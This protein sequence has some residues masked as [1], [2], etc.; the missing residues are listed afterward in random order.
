LTFEHYMKHVIST[1]ASTRKEE[2]ET[3][4]GGKNGGITLWKK[5]R[6]FQKGKR[7]NRSLCIHPNEKEEAEVV[8]EEKN[9]A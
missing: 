6:P 7:R 1:T 9:G 2:A 3:V 5:Q 4:P 8:L